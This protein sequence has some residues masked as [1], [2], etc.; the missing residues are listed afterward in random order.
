MTQTSRPETIR[1]A[2]RSRY[3]AAAT[4]VARATTSSACCAAGASCCGCAGRDADSYPW[5]REPAAWQVP[6]MSPNTERCSAR[7]A[8]PRWTLEVTGVYG[9][10]HGCCVDS[11]SPHATAFQALLAVGGPFV[12][13]SV[14]GT[15][16]N[17]SGA[18][19]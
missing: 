19:Q 5:R 16:P 13:A 7:L 10:E 4:A 15:K 3:A 12:S 14:R 17:P 8:L 9:T 2:V 6:S 11:C 1:D 18:I